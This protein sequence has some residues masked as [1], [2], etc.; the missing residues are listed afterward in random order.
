[1]VQPTI[2]QGIPGSSSPQSAAE[3]LA[4]SPPSDGEDGTLPIE[5]PTPDMSVEELQKAL[6]DSEAARKSAEG[7]LRKQSEQV[8]V[9]TD[10]GQKVDSL[11]SR[12]SGYEQSTQSVLDTLGMMAA[13]QNEEVPGQI[14]QARNQMQQASQESRFEEAHDTLLRQA[15]SIAGEAG[16]N[17][18]TAEEFSSVRSAWNA[19]KASRNS[20]ELATLMAEIHRVSTEKIREERD[21]VVSNFEKEK[22]DA[23]AKALSA[24]NIAPTDTGPPAASAASPTVDQLTSVDLRRMTPAQIKEY[25]Q[26]VDAAR[27]SGAFG[28]TS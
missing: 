21:S 28:P 9:L 23:V 6:A 20:H 2:L 25:S 16:L 15:K 22:T 5:T 13:G 12:L 4:T 24:Y 11:G 3:L 18:D 7:R 17:L 26:Q 1:M 10:I 8:D 19:A 27:K 14:V